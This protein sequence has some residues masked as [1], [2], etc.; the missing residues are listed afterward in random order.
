MEYSLFGILVLVADIYAIVK[1]W[2]SSASTV[3]KAR[4]Y[5]A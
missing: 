2:S 3:A 1:T 4:H 5:K